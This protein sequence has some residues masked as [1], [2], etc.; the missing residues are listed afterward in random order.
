MIAGTSPAMTLKEARRIR[1]AWIAGVA[2]VEI[3][4]ESGDLD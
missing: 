1:C 2:V 3:T 4:R